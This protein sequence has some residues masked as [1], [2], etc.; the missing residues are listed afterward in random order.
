MY[1]ERFPL[2]RDPSRRRQVVDAFLAA[3]RGGDFQALLAIL[4][5]D[6]VM[7]I[8]AGAGA[9]GGIQTFRGAAAV[10]GQARAYQR[11]T[12]T[13][14]VL[15]NGAVGLVSMENGQPRGLLSFTIA[16]GKI[17][18]IDILSDP[19][20]LARLDLTAPGAN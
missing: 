15:V 2:P 8:D 7:R 13:R 1:G 4:D 12:T 18:A 19:E 11:H 17:I 3:A 9:E 14:Q 20:R 6:V 5:P 10:A 16:D